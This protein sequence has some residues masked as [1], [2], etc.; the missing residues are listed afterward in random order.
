MAP[1]RGR[2]RLSSA[3]AARVAKRLA[4]VALT[5]LESVD[6]VVGGSFVFTSVGCCREGIFGALSCALEVLSI[7]ITC[8]V[9]YLPMI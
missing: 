1:L 4:H 5:G 7:I 9:F 3:T 8:F 2:T 6:L